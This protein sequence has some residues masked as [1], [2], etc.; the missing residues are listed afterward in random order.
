[1][2]VNNT[3]SMLRSEKREQALPN[4]LKTTT[5]LLVSSHFCM[6]REKSKK[7]WSKDQCVINPFLFSFVL[8]LQSWPGRRLL[9]RQFEVH[10]TCEMQGYSGRAT[11]SI[12]LSEPARLQRLSQREQARQRICSQSSRLQTQRRTSGLSTL[13]STACPSCSCKSPYRSQDSEGPIKIIQARTR[14][15]PEQKYTHTPA[16]TSSTCSTDLHNSK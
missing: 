16:S 14:E 2:N 13:K 10:R 1:M 12:A 11:N 9:R 5:E 6:W 3:G 8:P 4:R 7:L 15:N